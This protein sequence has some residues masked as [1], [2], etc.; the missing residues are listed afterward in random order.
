MFSNLIKALWKK[1]IAKIKKIKDAE[2][3]VIFKCI[4]LNTLVFGVRYNKPAMKV[5]MVAGT[6]PDILISISIMQ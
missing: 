4:V 1:K 6:T 3:P 2:N 5:S